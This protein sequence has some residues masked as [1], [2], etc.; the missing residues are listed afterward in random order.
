MHTQQTFD[1]SPSSS[2]SES[3]CETYFPSLSLVEDFG[4]FTPLVEG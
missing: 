2:E 1:K 4:K 3:S